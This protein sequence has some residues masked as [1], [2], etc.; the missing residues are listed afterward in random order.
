MAYDEH[1]PPASEGSLYASSVA[2]TP[3]R[4]AQRRKQLMVGVAGAAA[5]LAGAGFL[6]TQLMNEQQPA[7]PEPAAL[8]PRTAPVTGGS[9]PEETEPPATRTP[10]ITKQA[11]PVERSPVPSAAASRQASPDPGAARPS[12][13]A[14]ESR[15]H[16][17]QDAN[18]Q[19][20]ERVEALGDGSVR[21]LSARRD[22]SGEHPLLLAPGDGEPAGRGVRCTS[23]I[24]YGTA[25]PSPPPA[26]LMCWR[27]SASRSVIT[28][29]SP[30][31]GAAPAAESVEVITREW[32]R[33]D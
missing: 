6:V 29:V 21:I 2:P 14:G 13:A 20:A 31:R 23:E 5:V 15:E 11:A 27:T 17:G 18:T 12:V 10:K 19:V 30:G 26:T 4:S 7:L 32:D 9:T 33:L 22:L 28:M 1:E 16:L 25:A 8:A 24:R 3:Q